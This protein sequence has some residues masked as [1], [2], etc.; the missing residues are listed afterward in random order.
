MVQGYSMSSDLYG[1]RGNT[2]PCRGS[3][4]TEAP[5]ARQQ[6]AGS[7]SGAQKPS[8]RLRAAVRAFARQGPAQLH[9]RRAAASKV[10]QPPGYPPEH[11]Q[12]ASQAGQ[13]PF[14]FRQ[15]ENL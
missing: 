12:L 1:V 8:K 6:L 2:R 11:K 14:G 3:P 15:Q 4:S 10:T 9:A 7:A 13:T 5:E